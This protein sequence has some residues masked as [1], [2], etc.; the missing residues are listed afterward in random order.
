MKRAPKS[1]TAS[2][3]IF[4]F[5]I[6]VSCATVSAP[7]LAFASQMP[8]CSPPGAVLGHTCQHPFLCSLTDSHNLLTQGTLVSARS[9]DCT[10]DGPLLG[11]V[12][13]LPAD[14]GF[15]LTAQQLR[16]GWVDGPPPKVPV[17][18]LNSVLTL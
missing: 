6:G 14:D 9:S 15:S 17:Y 4:I 12:A 10:K 5:A 11:G 13:P 7:A 18:L 1:L 3:L 16:T 8:D 2:A